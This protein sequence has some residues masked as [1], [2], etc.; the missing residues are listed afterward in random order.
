MIP[1]AYMVFPVTPDQRLYLRSE[2]LTQIKSVY[3][4]SHTLFSHV[5]NLDVTSQ[6]LHFV[7]FLNF[8]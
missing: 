3:L 2:L 6:V 4:P 8:I 5:V 1:L 7:D